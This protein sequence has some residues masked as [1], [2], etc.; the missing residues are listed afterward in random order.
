[1][2]LLVPRNVDG[3]EGVWVHLGPSVQ[4]VNGCCCRKT[5]VWPAR[6][7]VVIEEATGGMAMGIVVVVEGVGACLHW[8]VAIAA[9]CDEKMQQLLQKLL[10]VQK[11]LGL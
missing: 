8:E 11:I 5:G 1:M 4:E 10:L 6:F 9:V 2:L 3:L 7:L